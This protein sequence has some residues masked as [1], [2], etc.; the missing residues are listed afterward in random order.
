VTGGA[1][2]DE[3]DQPFVTPTALAL[4]WSVSPRTLERWR[5]AATGPAWLLIGGQ[6]RYHID[7]VLAYEAAA[8]RKGG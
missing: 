8:R 5:V 4:R 3:T 6:V 7:D 1:S 2:A